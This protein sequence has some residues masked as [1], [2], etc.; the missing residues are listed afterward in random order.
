MTVV[1]FAGGQIKNYD[2]IK[3][4]LSKNSF[5]ICADSGANHA[6]AMSLKPDLIIGDMDSVKP[7]V[8]EHFRKSG[9][10]IKKYPCDKDKVDTELAIKQALNLNPSEIL[11]LGAIGN[12]LDHTLANVHLLLPAASFGVRAFIIDEH[13]KIS[14]ITKELPARII[15][16]VG[17]LISLLP[18]STEVCGVSSKGLKWELNNHKFS[19]GNPFG[20]S[21]ELVSNSAEIKVKNG[22]LLLIET[23]R[24]IA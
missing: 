13:H 7:E 20:I 3:R 18:I 14:L 10:I 22:S 5:I 12:R 24:E 15:G 1:I 11:I 8:L 9:V 21:N 23:S 17:G 4:V 2:K 16:N 6:Y 19:I